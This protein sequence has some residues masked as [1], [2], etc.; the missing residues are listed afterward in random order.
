MNLEKAIRL[1]GEK[2]RLSLPLL[3]LGLVAIGGNAQADESGN[4]QERLLA[5]EGIVS[6]EEQ[7][8]C[9]NAVVDGLDRSKPQ[10]AQ[11]GKPKQQPAVAPAAAAVPK[12]TT[13]PVEQ[14]PVAEAV[15]PEPD[16]DYGLK[17]KKDKKDKNPNEA[18]V[19][20]TI[21][22]V[23]MNHDQRFSVELDNGQQWRETQGTNVG[24]PKEGASVAISSGS[25]GSYRMK[26]DGITR[27]AWV[28]RTK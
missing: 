13:V 3:L 11:P 12:S 9:F 24:K 10:A 6:Q 1:P 21:V 14:A 20:A 19:M 15:I 26:I 8:E 18:A 2:Q 16:S 23:W 4:L 25:F 28:R 27:K 22:R 7:L 17:V 5:C